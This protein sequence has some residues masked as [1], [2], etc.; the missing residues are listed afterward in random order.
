MKFVKH[1]KKVCTKSTILVH[2]KAIKKGFFSFTGM[3][4]LFQILPPEIFSCTFFYFLAAVLLSCTDFTFSHQI[5]LGNLKLSKIN[6]KISMK[7]HAL[8]K[9]ISSFKNKSNILH[10]F[11]WA[12]LVKITTFLHSCY[13]VDAK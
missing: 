1:L 11:F 3:L 9:K 13:A 12:S 4:F 7:K 8:S 5:F 6:P 10:A 2:G